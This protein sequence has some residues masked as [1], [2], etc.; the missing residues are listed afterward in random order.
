MIEPAVETV[1]DP[2][3]D[4]QMWAC[5]RGC[6]GVCAL[7]LTTLGAEAQRSAPARCRQLPVDASV[8]QQLVGTEPNI[9]CHTVTDPGVLTIVVRRRLAST[10]LDLYIEVLDNFGNRVADGYSDRDLEGRLD[11][12]QIVVT[13]SSPIRYE[14]R[15]QSYEEGGLYSIWSTWIALPSEVVASIGEEDDRPQ[16]ATELVVNARRPT[17]ATLEIADGDSRDWWYIANVG[18]EP[19]RVRVTVRAATGDL[20]LESYSGGDFFNL[21]DYSD[22]DIGGNFGHE[23]LTLNLA[24]GETVH[25]L[26]SPF[27]SSTESIDY[28]ISAT[29][30]GRRRPE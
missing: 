21:I 12:E 18:K 14:I 27:F 10:E 11:A 25:L 17:S 29:R 8:E 23:E 26:V 2:G 19:I 28:E 3:D 30:V 20:M 7:I 9:Y 16:G 6:V 15:V 4:F 13:L 24:V 5:V 22:S 1:G